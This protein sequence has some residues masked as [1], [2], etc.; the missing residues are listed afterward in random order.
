MFSTAAMVVFS[1]LFSIWKRSSLADLTIKTVMFFMAGWA[2][3]SA[4]Q[5]WG[6]IITLKE[7]RP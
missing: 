7:P 4:A 2:L 1:L 3:F 6:F 5:D